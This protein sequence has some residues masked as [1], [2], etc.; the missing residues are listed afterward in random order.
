MTNVVVLGEVY[1]SANEEI[2][3]RVVMSNKNVS[4]VS[5]SAEIREVNGKS[6]WLSVSRHLSPAV[7]SRELSELL[8]AN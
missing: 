3:G 1:K 8:R 5:F 2:E 7:A 6:D 4:A